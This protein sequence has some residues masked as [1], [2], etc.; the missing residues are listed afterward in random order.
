MDQG[1][2]PRRYAKAL[3]MVAAENHTDSLMYS[4]L[5]T[6][7]DAFVAEPQLGK[8]MANPFIPA[9]DKSALLFT[10]AQ[11]SAADAPELARF[12]ALLEENGRMPMVRDIVLAYLGIYRREHHIYKV[13]VVSAAEM[14]SPTRK[15][16]ESL[17]EGQIPDGS[18]EYSFSVDPDLLGGFTVSID[19]Q[20]LDASVKNELKQLRLKLLSNK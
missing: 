5:N 10:A 8:T 20:R 4:R 13:D 19:N 9:A 3:Y 18:M 6:L 17:I 7:V 12:F 11:T 2:I 16:L 1:L 14:P 15:R